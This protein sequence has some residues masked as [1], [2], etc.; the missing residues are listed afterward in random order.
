MLQRGHDVSDDIQSESSSGGR[1]A[2]QAHEQPLIHLYEASASFEVRSEAML[3]YLLGAYFQQSQR[4]V[5]H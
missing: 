4:V 2:P 5:A 3:A 1:L